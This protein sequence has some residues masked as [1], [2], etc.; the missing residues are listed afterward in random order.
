MR[1]ASFAAKHYRVHFTPLSPVHIGDGSDFEPVNFVV[2]EGEERLYGFNPVRV[3]LTPEERVE[4]GRAALSRDAFSAI[5][6]FYLKR[7]EKYKSA[8]PAIVPIDHAAVANLK[9]LI[10]G[11][12]INDNRIPK[13]ASVF[14]GGDRAPYVPGSSLKGV[15]RTAMFDNLVE[16]GRGW[17]IEGAKSVQQMD[18]IAYGGSM[19]KSPFRYLK[20]GDLMPEESVAYTRII[21]AN[22][23]HKKDD[24]LPQV[25]GIPSYLEVI[26]K[27]QYRAFSG[28]LAINA[29][30]EKD[31]TVPEE[32]QSIESLVR[33]LNRYYFDL[34]EKESSIWEKGNKATR[35]WFSEVSRLLSKLR[36]EMES[37]KVALIRIG[38]N[39]GAEALTI[40]KLAKIRIRKPF[41]QGYFAKT[42]STF[43]SAIEEIPGNG[44]CVLPFGWALLEIG[45]L[46]GTV[47]KDW[48]RKTHL[49]DKFASFDL[50]QA[51]LG[52]KSQFEKELAALQKAQCEK[53]AEEKAEK[54]A[55]E[56]R[57]RRVAE[58]KEKYADLPENQR[59][60]M[61]LCEE[62]V[63]DPKGI[64]PGSELEK[65]KNELFSRLKKSPSDFLLLSKELVKVAKKR[66]QRWAK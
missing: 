22:R 50:R 30:R 6:K 59:L 62:A 47:L 38:H 9:K 60:I 32:M 63:E 41:G 29:P 18:D 55:E 36:P 16:H 37:G 43:F 64:A 33:C 21:K 28:D 5:Q 15:I 12:R 1:D 2:D 56:Q 46:P 51:R 48:C 8:A 19:G 42:A 14:S 58:M 10:Q 25:S 11:S 66:K 31:A 45:D 26:E 57:K 7:L 52:L 54:E 39:S 34:F 4:L 3:L 23:I 65:R 13:T 61:E 24:P 44:Q 53:H 49:Q 20:A 35:E 27:A 17:G 40:H